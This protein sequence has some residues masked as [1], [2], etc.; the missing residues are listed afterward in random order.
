MADVAGP[1]GVGAMT[2]AGGTT[3]AGTFTVGAGTTGAGT[4]GGVGALIFAAGVGGSGV[5]TGGTVMPAGG[6]GIVRTGTGVAPGE[7]VITGVEVMRVPAGVA[8]RA[9]AG[10]LLTVPFRMT[11]TAAGRDGPPKRPEGARCTRVCPSRASRGFMPEI[12]RG[13]ASARPVVCFNSHLAGP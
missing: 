11:L 2:G 9:G 4:A 12:M 10:L 7:D 3:A 6:G 1:E 13:L 5:T 8:S